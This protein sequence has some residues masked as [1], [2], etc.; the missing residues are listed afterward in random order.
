M[1][2][3]GDFRPEFINITPDFL[4]ITKDI[5]ENQ[6][7]LF[8][9]INN[10]DVLIDSLS[11]KYDY[12]ENVQAVY[13]SISKN[14]KKWSFKAGIRSEITQS[15][16]KSLVLDKKNQKHY[17]DFFPTIY[18]S[19]K[20]NSK[21]NISFSY[22]DRIERPPYQYLDPF[23]WYITKYDYAQGNPFLN[24]SYIKNIELNYLHNNS[25]SAKIYYTCQNDK[26]GKYVVLDSLNIKNQ[27]Q[28][29]DNFLNSKTYGISIYKL[30]KFK[31]LETVLQGNFTY[32]E[33]L[34]NRKE[35]S[36]L[37]GI[38][39]TFIMNNT[40]YISKK[41]SL[42]CNLEEEIPGLYNYRT[43]ENYFN[44]DIGANFIHSDKGFEARLLISD[45][46]KT[47]NPEYSYESGGIKQTYKNY[48]DSR[49][50][51]LVLVW[52]L[53][54]WYNKSHQKPESSNIEEKGRL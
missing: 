52:K 18:I 19:H 40:F 49:F 1:Q 35:F 39:G 36:D 13:C 41:I 42:L 24:P 25:F 26:I 29:T 51:K 50:L 28:K 37:S 27:I 15:V 7:S 31:R 10:N 32:S 20:I 11:N 9:I 12:N 54:N 38:N 23:K 5:L 30:L 43:M 17:I 16:G 44:L 45:I 3:D 22:S 53:G 4:L 48:Y 33:F 21:N 2:F 6:Q 8:S 14:I 46:F 47:A 34:S